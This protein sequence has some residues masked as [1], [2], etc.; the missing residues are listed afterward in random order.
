MFPHYDENKERHQRLITE[1]N[2]I[3]NIIYR[4]VY[5]ENTT[6]A[7]AK[8]TSKKTNHLMRK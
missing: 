6:Q 8:E 4:F 1:L 5:K 2:A 7:G 3:R